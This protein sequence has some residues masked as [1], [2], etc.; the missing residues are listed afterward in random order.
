M[1]RP[2]RIQYAGAIYHAIARGNARKPIFRVDRDYQRFLEGME[3]T[4]DKFGFEVFGFVC[5]PN[6]VHLA[7]Q[8]FENWEIEDLLQSWKGF[9][10]RE[11]AKV[12]GEPGQLWQHDNWNRI[13]RDKEHW[14]RVMRYIARN[15]EK[16]KLHDGES[17]VWI[18]EQC[19]DVKRTSKFV[20]QEPEPSYGHEEDQP[21]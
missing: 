9:T 15:P 1:A 10:S 21:W 20:L 5:M 13:I 4:V 12:T 6:H 2:L 8:P 7:C 17:T 19:R 11:M 3:A 16:A 14:Q 18:A